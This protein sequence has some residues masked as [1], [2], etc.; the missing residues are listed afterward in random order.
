MDRHP[1]RTFLWPAMLV[2]LGLT[3]FPFVYSL[4]LSFNKWNLSDRTATWTY[5]GFANYVGILTKDPYFWSAVK[6]TAIYLTATVTIEFV[7]G[8]VIAFLISQEERFVGLIRTVIV[9]PMMTTPAVVGL[10]WRFMYN[11]ELGMINYFLGV[12]GI[13]GPIWLGDPSTALVSVMIADV[14]EWTPFMI[15]IMLAALQS[16][17]T[18]PLEAGVVDGASRLQLFRF[19]VLPTIQPAIVVALLLRAIDSFKTFDL[20]YVLT[21]GGPGITTQVLS[22]YTYKWGFKFFEM[23]Y[24]AAMSYA[25]LIAVDLIATLGM[26]FVTWQSKK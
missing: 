20:I 24:A 7:L 10:I 22:L 23:G 19:I 15:L 13:K 25:M 5:V 3:I 21:Q 4:V 9:I 2:L 16:V 14:W 18:E 1:S 6:V 26:R 17:A 11:P 12:I 8:L